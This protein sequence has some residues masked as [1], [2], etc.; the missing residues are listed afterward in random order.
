MK[1][2]L[3]RFAITAMQ[4]LLALTLVLQG[5]KKIQDNPGANDEVSS[6]TDKQ[7]LK[8]VDIKLMTDGLVSPIGL[9]AVP[10]SKNLAIIDQIGKIW[11]MDENGNRMPTPFMDVSGR[12]TPLNPNYDERGLLGFAFHPDYQQN[13]KFYLYYNRPARPGGPVPGANWTM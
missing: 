3:T 6:A 2:T 8:E 1:G 12:I 4:V 9:V 5:C 13:G 7:K 10:G 11:M